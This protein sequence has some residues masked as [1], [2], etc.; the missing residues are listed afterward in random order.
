MATWKLVVQGYIALD[1]NW[2]NETSKH[3]VNK[4]MSKNQ[5]EVDD[6]DLNRLFN[7]LSSLGYSAFTIHAVE[8]RIVLPPPPPTSPCPTCGGTGQVK[9]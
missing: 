1:E 9:K 3:V 2:V 4:S 7:Y 5:L 8:K 6:S